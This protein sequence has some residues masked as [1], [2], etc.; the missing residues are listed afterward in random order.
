MSGYDGGS[1]ENEDWLIS[2]ALDFNTY[3]NETL[4]FE[5]ASNYS[6]PEIEVL[7]SNEYDGMGDPNDYEWEDISAILSPGGWSWI[8]SGN[9]DVSYMTGTAV[10]IG[11]KYTST[12]SESMTWEIDDIVITGEVYVGE[13]EN[14]PELS[15]HLYPNPARDQV[16]LRFAD[17]T[18]KIVSV[19]SLLGTKVAQ[20]ETDQ[21]QLEL[22]LDNLKQ[23]VYLVKVTNDAGQRTVQK[24]IKQ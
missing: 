21:Q 2:P 17:Q 19:H 22:S 18:S 10:Y 11:F 16:Q 6:G 3:T 14:L 1:N 9:I 4:V 13:P 24:L 23:G 15:M 7:I 8:N 12:S 5:T 20:F